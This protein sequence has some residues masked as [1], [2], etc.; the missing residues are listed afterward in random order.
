MA[1]PKMTDKIYHY[2]IEIEEDGKLNLQNKVDKL[3]SIRESIVKY[4]SNLSQIFG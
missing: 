3:S 4:G 2:V 1:G